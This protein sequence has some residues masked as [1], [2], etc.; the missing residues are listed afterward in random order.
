M[1]IM[2]HLIQNGRFVGEW[3]V[4][5]ELALIKQLRG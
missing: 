3:T 4:F 1:G 5:D 2:H